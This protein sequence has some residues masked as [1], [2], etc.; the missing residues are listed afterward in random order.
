MPLYLL[1]CVTRVHSEPAL[2]LSTPAQLLGFKVY[3]LKSFEMCTELC[4]AAKQGRPGLVR[5][6]NTRQ[7]QWSGLTGS[8][9]VKGPMPLPVHCS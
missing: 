6:K 5:G 1:L 8:H 7:V 9:Y 4:T 2:A 3:A